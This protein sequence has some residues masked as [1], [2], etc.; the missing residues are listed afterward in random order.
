MYLGK[1]SKL[2]NFKSNRQIEILSFKGN[3]VL[4]FILFSGVGTVLKRDVF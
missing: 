1:T 4:M 3:S 2:Q